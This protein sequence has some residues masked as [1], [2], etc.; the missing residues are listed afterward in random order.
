MRVQELNHTL[1]DGGA[2]KMIQVRP[3]VT[4]TTTYDAG[5]GI[6]NGCMISVQHLSGSSLSKMYSHG[7]RS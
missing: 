7:L 4:A 6:W 3:V 5:Q 2:A 1:L